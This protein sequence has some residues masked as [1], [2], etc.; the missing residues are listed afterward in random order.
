MRQAS[1]NPSKPQTSPVTARYAGEMADR[2]SQAIPNYQSSAAKRARFITATINTT[3]QSMVTPSGRW[4]FGFSSMSLKL[5]I[6]FPTI[7]RE[8]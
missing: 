4:A 2:L 8:C 7:A 5:Q 1:S 6:A 3:I